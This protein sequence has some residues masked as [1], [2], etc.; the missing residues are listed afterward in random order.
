MFNKLVLLVVLLGSTI[1]FAETSA[2]VLQ[3][4]SV[5]R[6]SEG[7]D[8]NSR[9]YRLKVI[10]ADS[11]KIILQLDTLLCIKDNDKVLL[12]SFPLSHKLVFHNNKDIITYEMSKASIQVTNSEGTQELARVAINPNVASQTLVIKTPNMDLKTLDL[13]IQSLLQIKINDKLS[14]QGMVFGGNYRIIKQ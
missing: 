1:S 13:T 11:A 7:G 2:V 5:A 6:C 8:A 12:V 9:A 3:N 14:D 4:G 10:S